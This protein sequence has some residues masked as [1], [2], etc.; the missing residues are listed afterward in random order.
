ML[1]RY[2]KALIAFVGTIATALLTLGTNPE[3]VG[4]IPEGA[5]NWLV[6]VAGV[7][8]TTVLGYLVR[9]QLTIDQI[10][11]ALEAGDLS[12]EDLKAVLGRR[13]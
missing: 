5:T 6:T 13:G 3:I 8:G 11:K 2:S 7:L 10:D 12:L 1:G 9:N 4:A